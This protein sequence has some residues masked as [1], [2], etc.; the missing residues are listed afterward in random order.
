M[1]TISS[2][3]SIPI[4]ITLSG[5]HR[6]FLSLRS[7]IS[8]Y[9]WDDLPCAH[10]LT[11]FFLRY[12]SCF[13]RSRWEWLMLRSCWTWRVVMSMPILIKGAPTKTLMHKILSAPLRFW[14]NWVFRN[15]TCSQ[16]LKVAPPMVP[17]F[18]SNHSISGMSGAPIHQLGSYRNLVSCNLLISIIV[19]WGICISWV[20]PRDIYCCCSS[21]FSTFWTSHCF[22]LPNFRFHATLLL[23]PVRYGHLYQFWWG[24]AGRLARWSIL[25]KRESNMK[26]VRM[27]LDRAGVILQNDVFRREYKQHADLVN[28]VNFALVWCVRCRKRQCKLFGQL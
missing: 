14:V 15:L 11:I 10:V 22:R 2:L 20:M 24:C 8:E 1:D 28:G 6:V 7:S 26:A 21:K 27:L 16:S 23:T 4:E 18:P 17:A 12:S 9:F 5:L 25:R 3:F 13:L 19:S